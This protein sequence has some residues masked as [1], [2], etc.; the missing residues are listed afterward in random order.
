MGVHALR[1][2]A[3]GEMN[4]WKCLKNL[5]MGLKTGDMGLWA[6]FVIVALV[7][8]VAADTVILGRGM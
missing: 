5:L 8:W 6:L 1:F 7:V 2:V 3:E 4:T